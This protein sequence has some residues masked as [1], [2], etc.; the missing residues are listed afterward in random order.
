MVEKE[1]GWWL[2][3]GSSWLVGSLGG[4]YTEKGVVNGGTLVVVEML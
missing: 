3:S 2:E 1:T 4:D